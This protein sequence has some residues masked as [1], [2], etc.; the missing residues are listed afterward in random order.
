MI[1]QVWLDLA[2]GM[3]PGAIDAIDSMVWLTSD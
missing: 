1:E 3:P 2:R